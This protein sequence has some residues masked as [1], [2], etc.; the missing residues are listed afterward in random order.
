MTILPRRQKRT[1]NK[2]CFLIKIKIYIDEYFL[3]KSQIKGHAEFFNSDKRQDRDSQE[4]KCL[5]KRVS[6]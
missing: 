5:K 1:E 4:D 3:K 6:T 2:A